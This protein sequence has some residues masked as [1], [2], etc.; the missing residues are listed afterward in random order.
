MKN[1]LGKKN[2]TLI[3]IC[4]RTHTLI[5]REK[6]LVSNAFFPVSDRAILFLILIDWLLLTLLLA[7]FL[8]SS[9]TCAC[10]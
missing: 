1:S 8:G 3:S 2:I 9:L 4:A 6:E 10:T 5:D 7:P